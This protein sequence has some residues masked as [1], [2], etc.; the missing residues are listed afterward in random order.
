MLS[1]TVSPKFQVVLPQAAREQMQIAVGQEMQVLTIDR[2]IVL[3]PI[4]TAQ[5]ARGFLAGIDTA[6]VRNAVKR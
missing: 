4:E 5:S 6:V 2:R 3:L 1:V